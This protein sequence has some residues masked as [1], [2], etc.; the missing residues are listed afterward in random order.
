MDDAIVVDYIRQLLAHEE[1]VNPTPV[2]KNGAEP[3]E[4]LAR[5]SL[6]DDFTLFDFKVARH[7]ALAASLPVVIASTNM[8]L[9]DQHGVR[10]RSP[11]RQVE[12]AELIVP[13]FETIRRPAKRSKA[14]KQD[15]SEMQPSDPALEAPIAEEPIAE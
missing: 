4:I 2:I 9:E 15:E 11:S 1:K 5:V 7:V 3:G 12:P 14:G 13:N 6:R 10:S 8:E